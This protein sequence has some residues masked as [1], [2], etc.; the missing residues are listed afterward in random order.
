MSF[1]VLP[2]PRFTRFWVK[3]FQGFALALCLLWSPLKTNGVQICRK[4]CRGS[5]A[6]NVGEAAL[7]RV[8]LMRRFI[9]RRS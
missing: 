5:T 4:F 8:F 3:V 6:K 9:S 2:K 7:R 1:N